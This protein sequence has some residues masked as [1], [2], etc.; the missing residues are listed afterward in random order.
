MS[1][2]LVV[3][4]GNGFL[5]WHL[6]VRLAA[7]T[8]WKV[9]SA[10][11]A[12]FGTEA[13][14]AASVA[15][16]AVVV[17]AAGANRGDPG[18]VAATNVRL[19]EQL[20]SALRHAGATP[21]LVFANSIQSDNIQGD[22]IH[23]ANI[24]G[25]NIQGDRG[26]PYGASKAAAGEILSSWAAEVGATYTD[27][28]LPNLFGEHGRPHY[29]SFVA[30]FCHEFANGREPHAH[31]PEAP[32]ELLHAQDAAQAILDALDGP[33]GRHRPQGVSSTVGEVLE[34]LRRFRR[35]Y[36][37]AGLPDRASQFER[38]LFSTYRSFLC[39]E[40]VPLRV[41]SD[42]RGSLVET[43][44]SRSG[45][46]QTFVSTTVPGEVRGDHYH[47]RKFE[48]FLVLRG[49]AEIRLR[50]VLHEPVTRFR[51]DGAT[52]AFVDMPAMW[53]HAIENIGDDELVTSFW[54]DELFDV[55]QPDTHR[56]TVA[57]RVG[58]SA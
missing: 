4:G 3:T 44:R 51:V 48:R 50:R 18:D 5:G 22:N 6:R 34:T 29:N 12:E 56:E 43:V 1:G 39:L 15:D 30:T 35:D 38:D 37:D 41:S 17:H 32:V 9:G 33:A 52:P 16:A 23:G 11:R 47:L 55:D 20:V 31:D 45:G 19:A 36:R 28:V 57:V 21:A 42:E 54:A 49:T 10:E 53:A 46:G 7:L 58:R 2:R 13:A 14:L 26:T 24:Q 40:P 27:I 8:D 25:D